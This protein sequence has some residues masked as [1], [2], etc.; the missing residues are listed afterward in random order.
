MLAGSHFTNDVV[1]GDEFQLIYVPEIF[2]PA[3][4]ELDFHYIKT[5]P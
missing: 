2:L 5:L 1:A 3:S 4:F